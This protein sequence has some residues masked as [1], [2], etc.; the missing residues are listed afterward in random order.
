MLGQVPLALWV[1]HALGLQAHRIAPFD[2]LAANPLAIHISLA[3]DI[4]N[5]QAQLVFAL[6]LAGTPLAIGIW[7]ARNVRVVLRGCCAELAQEKAL[8]EGVGRRV[9]PVV[10][11]ALCEV[12][13]GS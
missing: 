5:V 8:S 4:R 2:A 9:A 11:L 13:R 7:V 3:R 10:F 1:L 12:V 6:V